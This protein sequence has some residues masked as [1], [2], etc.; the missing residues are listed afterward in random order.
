MHEN[1]WRRSEWISITT[2]VMVAGWI[3]WASAKVNAWDVVSDPQI[4][5]NALGTRVTRLETHIS[6]KDDQISQQLTA[7][8]RRI[9]K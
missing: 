6:D 5:N 8:Y 7:I 3:W 1:K 4:G 2:L 9:D